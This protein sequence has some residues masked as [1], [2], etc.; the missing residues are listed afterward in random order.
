MTFTWVEIARDLMDNSE[1]GM[2][3]IDAHVLL[4]MLMKSGACR[5]GNQYARRH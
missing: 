3:G 2:H 4:T 1:Y 5:V